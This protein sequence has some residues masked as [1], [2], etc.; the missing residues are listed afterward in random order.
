MCLCLCCAPGHECP[1]LLAQMAFISGLLGS[2]KAVSISPSQLIWSI[3]THSR[4]P[5]LNIIS[6]SEGPHPS[7]VGLLLNIP[8]GTFFCNYKILRNFRILSSIYQSFGFLKDESTTY[9]Y[10]LSL[11]LDNFRKLCIYSKNRNKI[12]SR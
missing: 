11:E 7:K 8:V 4:G 5:S 10:L 12:N 3:P 9:S 1:A 6:L 2:G